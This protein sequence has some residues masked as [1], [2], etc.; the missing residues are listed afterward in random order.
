MCI[1]AKC[2]KNQCHT[3]IDSTRKNRMYIMDV[4]RTQRLRNTKTIVA[5]VT[6]LTDP[7]LLSWLLAAWPC[8]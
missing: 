8:W 2:E 3:T 7:V 5:Q 1:P 6:T 4:P